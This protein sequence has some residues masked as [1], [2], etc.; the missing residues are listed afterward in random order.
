MRTVLVVDDETEM[1]EFISEALSDSYSLVT[2][3]NGHE[4]LG[5]LSRQKFDLIVTDLMMPEMDGIELLMTLRKSSPTQKLIAMSGGGVSKHFDIL[6]AAEKLGS[7]PILRK[8]FGLA[9]L[10]KVVHDTLA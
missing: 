3:A 4:A 2:V 8:P 5:Q 10:R 7:C 1:R 6:R 9:E